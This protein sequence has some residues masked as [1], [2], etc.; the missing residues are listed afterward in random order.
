VSSAVSGAFTEDLEENSTTRDERVQ[1]TDNDDPGQS[2]NPRCQY[3]K[4]ELVQSSKASRENEEGKKGK[5]EATENSRGKYESSGDLSVSLVERS[6]GRGSCV[7]SSGVVV[8]EKKDGTMGGEQRL[9]RKKDNK[10]ETHDYGSGESKEA[11]FSGH[12]N[13]ESL[14]EI[15]G[16]FHISDERRNKSVTNESLQ[17]IVPSVR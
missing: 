12:R 1:D 14:G 4:D 5:G 3:E 11:E 10:I 7:F 16:M 2:V 17:Q 9:E 13:G 8:L 6:V 15:L